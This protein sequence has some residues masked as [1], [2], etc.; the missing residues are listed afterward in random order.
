MDVLVITIFIIMLIIAI[1]N[2]IQV[3]KVNNVACKMH[4]WIYIKQPDF[5]VEYI[6]C[7]VCNKTP[8]EI[9]NEIPIDKV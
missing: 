7:Q 2:S 9:I 8:T 3:D 4:K 5:D 6:V 1:K